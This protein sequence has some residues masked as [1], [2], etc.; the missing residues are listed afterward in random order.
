M[1]GYLPSILRGIESSPRKTQVPR[2]NERAE[3]GKKRTRLFA[4]TV[5]CVEGAAN[6]Q[7]EQAGRQSSP[8]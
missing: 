4:Q 2:R 6:K 3:E 1:E 7:E 5:T 8:V